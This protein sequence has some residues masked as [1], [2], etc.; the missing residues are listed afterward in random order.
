M[1]KE[2]W[3]KEEEEDGDGDGECTHR[4]H[5]HKQLLNIYFFVSL[6]HLTAN[7]FYGESVPL[8]AF[9]IHPIFAVTET[10]GE[11]QIDRARQRLSKLV[12][13]LTD[14]GDKL[15]RQLQRRPFRAALS[16]FE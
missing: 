2:K 12:L 5:P 10:E 1:E 4:E 13:T 6:E 15:R 8:N 14:S 9:F 7:S 3:Q 16:A 11:R